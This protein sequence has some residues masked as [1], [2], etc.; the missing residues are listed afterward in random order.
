VLAL[1]YGTVSMMRRLYPE[2]LTRQLKPLVAEMMGQG[3]SAIDEGG[4]RMLQELQARLEG[5]QERVVRELGEELAA[6]VADYRPALVMLEVGDGDG[7][8]GTVHLAE[9]LKD[10][11]PA[12]LIGVG[13]RK[14]AWFRGLMFKRVSAFD[15]VVFGDPED[16]VIGLAEVTEKRRT[17]E[18][19]P[20]I[21]F[22]ADRETPGDDAGSLDGL[23]LPLYDPAVYPAMAGDEKL[24]MGIIAESRGCNNRC[25]FCLHPWEDGDRQR[26]ASAGK[27]V[28]TM[29]LLQRH[30]GMS[31]FRFSGA[32]T[33][34][35]LMY[36]V[37]QEILQRGL[38]LQYNSFGHF[39]SANPDH[40]ETLAKSGLY[41]LFFGLESGC[42]EILDRAVQKGIKLER[43]AETMR[44]A[45]A[46]GIFAAASMIVPL[47]FDTEETMAESLRFVVGLQPDSVPLQFP[48][49]MPGTRWIA[50]PARYNLEVG[51]TERFLLDGLDYKFKQLFPPQFW[52]P[53]PYKVNGLSCRE[54]TGQTIRFAREL[55]AAGL[56][57]NFSH[58][59]AAIAQAA[60]MPPRQLRDLAQLW[61]VTGD[62]EAMGEM[63]VRANAAM[64]K[65]AP[66]S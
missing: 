58:T 51:D 42:Q 12:L 48:G 26:L 4:L 24:R 36:E 66:R 47:P 54:F 7:F 61:C 22:A 43:V 15:A 63:I 46:A 9:R 25:A 60:A 21:A 19:V 35:D 49:L 13:G 62:A 32:S 44:A 6:Q 28:D 29:Q 3:G 59:L 41:S 37:A 17:L 64:T 11:N 27:I 8:A 30:Y 20:G 2:A 14:A 31:N 16:A 57:T 52:E 55:E 38:Q 1:D 10:E 53:L 34:A 40:F 5:H 56:L 39:R 33:P 65:A 45:K 23:P 18:Q 50:D